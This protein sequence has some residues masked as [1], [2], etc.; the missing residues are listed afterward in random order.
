[1]AR[2]RAVGP[3]TPGL[4]PP[5]SAWQRTNFTR[6]NTMSTSAHA[7]NGAPQL[8]PVPITTSRL[9]EFFTERELSMQIGQPQHL[10]PVALL[11]E[12]IDNSV[13]ACEQAG[14]IHPVVEVQ[15]DEDAVSVED[16]G[17]GLPEETLLKSLDYAV[18]VSD[19][20]HY[21]SPTRGQLGNALKC[22][23]AAPFVADGSRGRVEVI[24]RGERHLIDVT[25]D[26]IAQRPR[27]LHEREPLAVADVVK[28]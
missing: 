9:M 22:L 2:S 4:P 26:R 3:T 20:S 1:M 24:T 8:H 5:P 23:W 25:L 6:T 13:D 14:V 7:G 11:K 28:S 21:I 18:R 16:N 27:L 15:V 19:K 10:W 17:P 12:L